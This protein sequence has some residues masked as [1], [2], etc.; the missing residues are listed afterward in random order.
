MTWVEM[1]QRIS[2]LE[3]RLRLCEEERDLLH[4]TLN[5]MAAEK[6]AMETGI[7]ARADKQA[8]EACSPAAD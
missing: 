4:D 6:L 2:E 3:R 8:G 7:E 5:E 1:E